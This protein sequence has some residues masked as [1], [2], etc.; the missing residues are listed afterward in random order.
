M[1]R[2]LTR[3]RVRPWRYSDLASLVHHAN[4]PRVART[5]K[6]LRDAMMTLIPLRGY[7]AI[8]VQHLTDQAGA[9]GAW[10]LAASS[11][12]VSKGTLA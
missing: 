8:T 6:M 3:C 1:D 4:D 2:I 11:A 7:N 9:K 5:R 12:E 10:R